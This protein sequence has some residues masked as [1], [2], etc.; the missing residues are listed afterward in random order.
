MNT[1]L[2]VLLII[3][4]VIT[5]YSIIQA[6]FSDDSNAPTEFVGGIIR[7]TFLIIACVFGGT[8]AFV[9][10]IIFGA[11]GNGMGFISTAIKGQPIKCMISLVL[12]VCFIVALAN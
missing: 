2:F 12:M 5:A 7:L 6:V 8:W 1:F 11:V 10:G 9:I 4:C 3:S